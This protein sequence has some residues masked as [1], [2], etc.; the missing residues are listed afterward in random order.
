MYVIP[1]TVYTHTIF[2]Q[3]FYFIKIYNYLWRTAATRLL[4]VPVHE[5]DAIAKSLVIHNTQNGL[6]SGR[7]QGQVDANSSWR[8][9]CHVFALEFGRKETHSRPCWK[10]KLDNKIK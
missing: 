9:L 5:K 4:F 7:T 6:D 3:S 2:F 10:H 8:R 1:G